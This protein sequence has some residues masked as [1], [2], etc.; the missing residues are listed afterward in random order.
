MLLLAHLSLLAAAAGPTL[1]TEHVEIHWSDGTARDAG[2]ASRAAEAAWE[3]LCAHT[4][5]P[6]HPVHLVVDSPTTELDVTLAVA[7]ALRGARVRSG[8]GAVELVLGAE[9]LGAP[10]DVAV[11]LPLRRAPPPWWLHGGARLDAQRLGFATWTPTDTSALCHRWRQGALDVLSPASA[12]PGLQGQAF[13]QWLHDTRGDQALARLDTAVGRRGSAGQALRDATGQPPGE[14]LAAWEQHLAVRCPAPLPLP[15]APAPGATVSDVST[16]G[17][18]VF[19]DGIAVATLPEGAVLDVTR[20]GPDV[21]AS[22]RALH[23]VDLWLLTDG[24]WTRLTDTPDRERHLAVDGDDLWFAADDAVVR[25]GRDGTA[26]ARR[27]GFPLAAVGPGVAVSPDGTW[28]GLSPLPVEPWDPGCPCEGDPS[29]QPLDLAT[30]RRS[31]PTRALR[32][33]LSPGLMVSPDGLSAGARV[34]L[35]GPRER[36]RLGADLWAGATTRAAIDVDLGALRL[37]AGHHARRIGYTHTPT[38]SRRRDTVVHRDAHAGLSLGTDLSVA[39]LA[40]VW[41]LSV[42]DPDLAPVG[43]HAGGA[44]AARW[45][46]PRRRARLRV[47]GGSLSVADGH[48]GDGAWFGGRLAWTERLPVGPTRGL[49]S[50]HGGWQSRDLPAWAELSA[51]A[52]PGSTWA[53]TADDAPLYSVPPGSVRGETLAV[54]RLGWGLALL[55]DAGRRGPLHL[56]LLE[57]RPE[58]ALGGAWSYDGDRRESLLD[59]PVRGA[60]DTPLLAEAGVVLELDASWAGAPWAGHLRLTRGLTPL[61]GF[62]DVDGDDALGLT[63]RE[64]LWEPSGETREPGWRV[65]IGLGQDW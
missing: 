42:A 5:C 31:H 26:E 41:Q 28:R 59:V 34:A 64:S 40:E 61:A 27:P 43:G 32:P 39:V 29:W 10:L 65:A 20:W 46:T 7:T 1:S 6:E 44:L 16:D 18:S 55:R 14:L 53:P 35:L 25:L 11:G 4:E 62:G 8:A 48:T 23:Q 45:D 13:L 52:H 17:A 50:L 22:L 36:T 24:A 63:L 38:S 30:E 37:G 2:Q 19:V 21:V 33:R 56:S 57:L 58:A 15:E 60:A 54:A 49:L 51:G 47:D 12:A 9:D 3:A